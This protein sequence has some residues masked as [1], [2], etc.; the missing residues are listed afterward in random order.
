M[1]WRFIVD[2]EVEAPDEFSACQTQRA[3]VGC[4]RGGGRWQ[5]EGGGA[6][7]SRCV[8]WVCVCVCVCVC[9][10]ARPP[11]LLRTHLHTHMHMACTHARAHA[12]GPPQL[13]VLRRQLAFVE[14][15]GDLGAIE[16]EEQEAL[17]ELLEEKLAQ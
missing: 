6:G 12:H 10:R 11:S 14:Q 8:Y 4:H 13:A 1:V 2:R 17:S 3:T 16:E 7:C 9:A 15:L 5:G